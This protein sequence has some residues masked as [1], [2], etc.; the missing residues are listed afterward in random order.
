MQEF[1]H[2]LKW[3]PM[4]VLGSAV[5]AAGFAFFLQPN[6]LSSGGISG[7]ALLLVELTGFGSVGIP[8]PGPEHVHRLRGSAM[9]SSLHLR[10]PAGRMDALRMGR[11][12]HHY[13]SDHRYIPCTLRL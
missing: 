13:S 1:G 6:D 7:L 9:R 3:I 8:R 10:I 5:F 11:D 2:K 12:S 4:T